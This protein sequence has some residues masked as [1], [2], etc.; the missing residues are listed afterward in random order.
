MAY[1]RSIDDD[2]K[3]L[4]MSSQFEINWI[5]FLVSNAI[6]LLVVIIYYFS[7]KTHDYQIWTTINLQL[8]QTSIIIQG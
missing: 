7:K 6:A 8:Y 1:H 4:V 3:L 5:A 2:D